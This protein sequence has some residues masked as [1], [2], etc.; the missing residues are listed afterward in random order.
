MPA[1]ALTL[2]VTT[3]AQT[4]G[5]TIATIEVFDGTTDLGP[6][7]ITLPNLTPGIHNFTA[8]VTDSFGV[9]NAFR[10]ARATGS[11][12]AQAPSTPSGLVTLT[13]SLGP[14]QEGRVLPAHR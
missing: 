3:T 10:L 8:V 1:A 6:A 9:Q 2:N 12:P 14:G 13:G 5:A 4:V 11:L 7:P